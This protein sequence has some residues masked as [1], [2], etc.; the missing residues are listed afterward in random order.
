MLHIIEMNRRLDNIL[1]KEW[2]YH[3]G[4]IYFADMEPHIGSEQGGSRPVIVLQND[5]GNRYS[6]T[7]IVATVTSRIAKKADQPTHV[8]IDQNPAFSRPSMVQTEQIFT[9]DKSRI[10]RFLGQ[11]EPHEMC[12]VSKAVI[13]SL[14][15]GAL[16]TETAKDIAQAMF[17]DLLQKEGFFGRGKSESA[18]CLPCDAPGLPGCSEHRPDV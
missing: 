10:Q 1:P 7:L 8:L 4:D 5:T 17:N 11:T 13:S 12:E 3:R 9:I 14:D 16:V 15:L 6:P 2:K 18:R